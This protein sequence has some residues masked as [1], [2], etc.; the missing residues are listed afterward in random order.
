MRIQ[1]NIDF[2]PNMLKVEIKEETKE[3]MSTIFFLS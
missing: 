3:K 2:T 1:T